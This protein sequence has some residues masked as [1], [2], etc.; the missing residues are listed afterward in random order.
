MNGA[1]KDSA[2]KSG[3]A[4][5][6]SEAQSIIEA[7]QERASEIATEA[8]RKFKEAQEHGYRQGFNQGLADA[9]RKAVRLIEESTEVAERL[10]EEG[11]K[12]AVAIAGT[13]IDEHIKVEPEAAKKIAMRAIQEAVI[14]DNVTLVVCP[15][16]EPV[17][18][19]SLPQ[20]RR[21]AGNAA[22]TVETDPSF[23]RGSCMVR[24]DFGEIDATI[25][26]LLMSIR[27]RLG[28]V[29]DEK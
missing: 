23:R 16:D 27:E 13:I 3:L 25:E 29:E 1:R 22:V 15:D 26:T 5:A 9:A 8:E 12:L 10:A 28:I 6:L 7:A 17:M 2:S 24:T 14:G 4:S 20:L 21:I 19:Q 11:A 18:K